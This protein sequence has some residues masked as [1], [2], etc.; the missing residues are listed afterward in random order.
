M[1]WPK[2]FLKCYYYSWAKSQFPAAAPGFFLYLVNRTFFQIS[3]VCGAIAQWSGRVAMIDILQHNG[4]HLRLQEVQSDYGDC[5]RSRGR[6]GQQCPGNL[7]QTKTTT[8]QPGKSRDQSQKKDDL[9]YIRLIHR[10]IQNEPCV[11]RQQG[12]RT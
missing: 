5:P 9:Q 4:V 6:L 7:L 1:K 2:V 10:R 11:Q 12:R 3:K 8:C